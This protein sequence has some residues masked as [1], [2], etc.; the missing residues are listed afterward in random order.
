MRMAMQGAL[1]AQRA[2][3]QQV[4][5]VHSSGDKG[6]YASCVWMHAQGRHACG[7]ETWASAET[8]PA[9]QPQRQHDV[10]SHAAQAPEA[11]TRSNAAQMAAAAAAAVALH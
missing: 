8:R 9:K 10:A 1:Q 4:Q 11:P 5:H 2:R 3:F 7:K 6:T